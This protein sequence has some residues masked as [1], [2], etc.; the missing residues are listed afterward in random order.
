MPKSKSEKTASPKKTPVA[1]QLI[2]AQLLC[3]LYLL[4]SFV[5]LFNAMDFD[6]PE[7]LYVS[8]LNVVSLVFLFKHK[9]FF[10]VSTFDK[11]AKIYSGLLVGF[12]TVGC[13]SMITAI[14]VSESLVHLAR[15][16]NT[17]VAFYCLYIFIRHDPK[18]FFHFICKVSI[19]VVI[20]YSWKAVQYFSGNSSTARTSEFVLGFQ[21]CFSNINIYTAYLVVQL[22]FVIYGFLYFE[23]IWKYISGLAIFLAI[24]ALFFAASRTAVLSFVVIFII[25]IAYLL[26]GII[27]H[28]AKLKKETAF[29]FVAPFL[30]ILLVLNVNRIDKN[31]MN[32]LD[33]LLNT[34]NTDYYSGRN[35]VNQNYSKEKEIVSADVSIKIESRSSSGRF[36]LWKL[37]FDNFKE[38]P[39]LGVGYGN[40]KAVGKKTHYINYT[41]SKGAFANPRRAHSDFLEKLAETGI[42]G[43]LFY[44]SLFIAPFLWFIGLMRREKDFKTQYIYATVFLVAL[45]YTLDALLNFPLERAPIQLFFIISVVFILAFARRQTTSEIVLSS[46][47]LQLVIFG[48]LFL[49]SFASIASN[50]AVFKAYQLQREM[51]TDLSGKALFGDGKL[52]YSYENIK[53]RWRDYP[54]LSYVGTVNNVFLANYAIK[55]KKY[56]EALAILNT[57][58]S[59]NVDA[60]LVKAF[61]AEIYLNVKDNLDSAKHYSEQVFD[62][63]P[64][65]KTNYNMLKKIY[66]KDKDT[67]SLLKI[68]HHYTKHNYRDV[69][70]WKTKSNTM[71]DFT[72]DSELMLKILDTGLA[73]NKFSSKIV[74]AKKEVLGKLKFK[75]YLSNDEV[76]AKHQVAYDFFV[77]QQYPQARKVFEEIL[78]TNP[79]DYLSIQNI[80]II[81]LIN[82]NYLDAV[83]NL[84][85]V[86]DAQAFSDGK[87]EYSR[88]YCYEQLGNL[89]K[90]KEDYKTSRLKKYP[91]AISLPESK[92][93]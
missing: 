39:V 58:Q 74:N 66:L 48:V 24:V 86:I 62:G 84:S 25:T 76:K 51:R 13:L 38:N 88:G 54:Q 26:Y 71:Y 90:A 29:L 56:D 21:H 10:N 17:I 1:N 91:Q 47:K 73:Y 46:K 43:F 87:A 93:K 80:G 67:A 18:V 31:S 81:D 16:V 30:I 77:K 53:E 52:K 78:K 65:F 32:T 35:Y 60:F 19:V 83:K 6:A 70:E 59:Y 7:W 5:P 82:K 92:Y 14:N 11:K 68:M 69:S 20:F 79:T 27:K 28:S 85:K 41:N 49:F 9:D 42:V 72:K 75:S 89:E 12:F 63:Y 22:P 15:F 40:Y 3:L 4:T 8:L 2:I 50:Y 37:A 45:G 23:K 36:S 64:G 33:D 61:K 44:V 55:A 57:S 34:R